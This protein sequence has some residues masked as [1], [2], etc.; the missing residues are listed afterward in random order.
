MLLSFQNIAMVLGPAIGLYALSSYNG[1]M[2]IAIFLPVM[3]GLAMVLS[4][5]IPLS[6]ELALPKQSKY[7][8]G[9]F[10]RL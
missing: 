2:Y 7:K 6:K 4:N 8:V 9:I 1:S 10:H 3:T 5:I